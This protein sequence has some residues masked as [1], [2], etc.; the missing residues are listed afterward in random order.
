VV[1]TD[2]ASGKVKRVRANGRASVAPCDVRGRVTGPSYEARAQVLPDE[3]FE[4]ANRLL[5]RKYSR[6]K[7]V[8]DLWT[9]ITYG[10][11]RKARPT[12][13]C[14]EVRLADPQASAS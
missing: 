6:L 10:L 9:K 8:I 2:L 11:R 14:I 5:A 13:V 4:R 1:W 12:E 7:P 3:A